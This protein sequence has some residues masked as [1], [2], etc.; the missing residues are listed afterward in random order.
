MAAMLCI[1]CAGASKE[2]PVANQSTSHTEDELL[3]AQVREAV[4]S[5]ALPE[6][7][8]ARVGRKPAFDT[9]A[10]QS[11]VLRRRLDMVEIPTTRLTCFPELMPA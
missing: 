5:G 1:G 8:A 10:G 9:T 4:A 6:A 7:L 2:T 11:I 3:L